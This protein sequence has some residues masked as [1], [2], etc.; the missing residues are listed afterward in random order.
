MDASRCKKRCARSSGDSISL[1][2][3]RYA[4]SVIIMY[5]AP[6]GANRL[7]TVTYWATPASKKKEALRWNSIF[8][9]IGLA[10]VRGLGSLVVAGRLRRLVTCHLL[11]AV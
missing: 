1:P 3:V 8:I 10:G 11:Y 4:V 5:N 9:P 2:Q 7:D 6:P